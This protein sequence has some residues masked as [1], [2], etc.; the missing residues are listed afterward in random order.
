MRKQNASALR[1]KFQL[2]YTPMFLFLHVYCN[3]QVNSK[4][5]NSDLL[6]IS[7]PK[8]KRNQSLW[9]LYKKCKRLK[10]HRST[11]VLT[12]LHDF[13]CKWNANEH[14]PLIMIPEIEFKLKSLYSIILLIHWNNLSYFRNQN[15]QTE[16]DNA[17]E[18]VVS[19]C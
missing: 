8:W 18:D 1:A 10:Q 11:N 13:S 16:N 7:Q 5:I 3:V 4:S 6:K 19:A 12:Y 9:R 17:W 14:L 2:Y 15:T